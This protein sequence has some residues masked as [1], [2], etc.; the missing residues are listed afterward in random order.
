MRRGAEPPSLLSPPQQGSDWAPVGSPRTNGVSP[1]F[2]GGGMAGQR[3]V[4]TLCPLTSTPAGGRASAPAGVNQQS[5]GVEKAA[6]GS[7]IGWL[8]LQGFVLL[9]PDPAARSPPR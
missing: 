7:S 5:P 3:V 6:A 9:P 1:F 4:L 8:L 2:W